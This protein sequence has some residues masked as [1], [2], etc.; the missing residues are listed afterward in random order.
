MRKILA[1]EGDVLRPGDAGYEEARAVWNGRFDKRPAMIARC[2]VAAD[3]SAAVDFAR[4]HEL[5]LAVRS[6]GHDYAGNSSCAGGLVIDL[7][8]MD[9]VRIDAE[10]KAAVV[11]AGVTWAALDREAQVFGLATTGPTV[12]TVGVAGSTLGGG[13][14]HLSRKHGLGVDNLVSA[15]IVTADGRLVRAS[16]DE[17]PDLVWA[18][19]GGGGNFGVVTSVEFQLHEVGP[20]VVT[21]Q[22]F[23]PF[24]HARHV[25]RGFREFMAAAPDEIMC[26]AMV[27]RVPPAE[28]FPEE[29]HGKPAVALI[30]CHCGPTAEGEAALRPLQEFGEP[31]LAV[32]QPIPY[33][34]LQQTFD[35]G[36]PKGL[37]WYSRSHDL[38]E[39]SDGVIDMMIEYTEALPGQFTLA[40]FTPMGGAIGRV[41]P[42]ATAFAHRHAPYSLHIFPGWSDPAED[43]ELMGWTRAFHDAM[44]PYATGGVYVNLL[45]EDEADRAPA[46]YGENYERLAQLKARWDPNNLFQGNHNIRPARPGGDHEARGAR[47]PSVRGG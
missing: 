18:L 28:P 4:E 19:R 43:Q 44:T 6:T 30:A 27:L 23:Y 31:M 10:R 41:D 37:R 9:A 33:T 46:A 29:Y 39:L 21:A 45:G 32:V 15:E 42:T 40:Y 47:D 38:K 3:V 34:A 17:N 25:F 35:A 7:S 13:V 14:G 1:I 20:E 12:S 5:L 22:V 36:M 8:L 11:Q 26:F 16:D 24:A 2:R